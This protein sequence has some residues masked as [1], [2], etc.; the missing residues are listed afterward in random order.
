MLRRRFKALFVVLVML[1][2]AG[3]GGGGSS[4]SLASGGDNSRAATGRSK[5][6]ISFASAPGA[7]EEALVKQHGGTIKFRYKHVHGMAATLPDAAVDALRHNPKITAIEL[8]VVVQ[9][10][11]AE[12]SNTWGVEQIGAGDVQAGGNT[13]DGVKVAIIDTGIDRT[14]DELVGCYAGGWDF[15]N[16]DDEPSDD[17][18]HGTHVAGTIAAADDD[19]GVVG[20][21]PGAKVFAL[22]VLNSSGSGYSSAI[23]AAVD[24]CVDYNANLPEGETPIQVTNNSYGSSQGTSLEEA[25][26]Q[27]AANAGII[28]VCA[29]GNS[30]NPPGKGDNVGYPARYASCI[31][32]A[33][34]DSV[35]SRASF[36]STGSDVELAAPGVNILSCKLGGGLI[37]F[38]GTSMATPHVVGAVALC[39]S[40][41]IG[42]PRQALADTAVDLGASGR[43]TKYGF[44]RIDVAAAVGAPPP[45]PPP[46]PPPSGGDLT[47][48]LDV[49]AGPYNN[50]DTVVISAHV[51][52]DGA[53]VAGAT[54]AVVVTTPSGRQLGA[55]VTTN[56]SGDATA[57]YKVNAKRDG[58]GTAYVD[59]TASA[60]GYNDGTAAQATFEVN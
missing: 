49:D 13:G 39:I 41:G 44:G 23:I 31:A 53:D 21:A 18:G 4:D 48:T 47:V 37:A 33:A 6:L 5:V 9:T 8:D 59:A 54:V 40:A 42:D 3:C 38:N 7:A 29:A 1:G 22:K 12:L 56:G 16:N 55:T 27:A 10:T 25:A 20:V 51:T 26:F 60:S 30:G 45:P 11:D 17:H 58:S 50:R 52:S 34:T 57:Q 35:D 14:H 24:W 2:L 32:V 28:N 19:T 15:V 36:S 43:D 46:P